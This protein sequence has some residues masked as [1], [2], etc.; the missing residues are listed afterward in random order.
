M[1]Q[2][3]LEPVPELKQRTLDAWIHRAGAPLEHD[4][5][6]EYQLYKRTSATELFQTQRINLWTGKF[7][8]SFFFD[9]NSSRHG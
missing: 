6:L 2:T 8:S 3:I 9:K 5:L 7:K 1:D 4:P